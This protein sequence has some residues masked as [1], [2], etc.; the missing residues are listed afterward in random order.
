MSGKRHVLE[1]AALALVLFPLASVA[2][3]P[4]IPPR[5]ETP[6]LHRYD[7][8][9]RTPDADDPAI[10]VHP[11][12]P[13]RGLVIGVLKEAGL[14]VHDLDGRVVQTLLPPNRP[15]LLAEDPAA[16]GPRPDA[17]TSACPESE[18]GETFGRFN[19]VDIQYGFPLRGTDG[20]VRKV[21]LAVVTDRGCDRLRI[22]AIDP[23]R[24][25]GPLLDVTARTAGRVFPERYVQPSPFQPTG[26]P[27][28]SRPNPLDD[29]STAYGLG[30]Y[31]DPSDR[32]HAFVTQ[33]SR[34]VVA[35]LELYEVGPEQ[36]GYRKVREFR[37]DPRFSIPTPDG[38]GR[39][40]WSPCREEPADDP[41]FEGLVVDQQEGI[42]YAAQEVVGLWKVPL[43]ASLPRVVDVPPSRLIDP[44]KSFGAPY[45]AVPDEG[46][47]TCE[48][49]A[50]APA[51]EGTIAVPGNP[52]VGGRHL[53]ADVEGLALYY[54]EEGE[55]YL[56]VS[57]QGD[58][59]LHLYDRE[60][61]W[62]RERGNR[63]L[64]SFQ[65]EGVGETDGHDVVNV[66]MGA[67][68]PRGLVVLQTGKA[69]PPPSTA[70][71]NG[72]PYDGSTQFK[73][74]RWD[75]IAEVVPPGFKVD[76]D[77][78]DPRDPHDD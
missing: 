61:G 71:V 33:R 19:N 46:E 59:T 51:S 45:W 4:V 30:L 7:E 77:G 69:A 12:R 42:L 44:V 78:Y 26:E 68:F 70:P 13:E 32:F 22:Y 60:G 41:Q 14:Q 27:V 64:G 24:A 29:Q 35:W 76:T 49:E 53:E 3:P 5:A 20:R 73:L 48:S 2:E 67:H 57:S 38:G 10:W 37:F 18:S 8:A 74:V 15:A 31:H 28:G 58:D 56:V 6:V 16:P 65:V 11:S 36:V 43:S 62:T 1:G 34:G 54:A 50:P 21:D 72:Y 75:D 40:S 47:Y 39:M 55:G 63:H 25:S 9:P 52:A 17:A 23:G 66:P